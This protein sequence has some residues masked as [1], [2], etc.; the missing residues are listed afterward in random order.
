[1]SGAAIE[2]LLNGD[3]LD[4]ARGLLGLRLHTAFGGVVTEVMVTE[5][6]AY[7]GDMDPASHAYRGRSKRNASMFETPGTLYVYRAYGIHWCMNV[8]VREEGVPHAVLLRGGHPVAGV[9]EMVRRRRREDHLA[10]GPGK[11][12]QALAVTGD[13]DGTSVLV[14][15]VVLLPGD[16]PDAAVIETTPR[17]GI[18]KAADRMWRFV[19]RV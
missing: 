19:A 5:V 14:G 15:P 9:D 7:A 11:L 3:V 13:H 17:V 16:L 2:R 6:E 1:M 12:T 4:A 8:V 10:D 18:S